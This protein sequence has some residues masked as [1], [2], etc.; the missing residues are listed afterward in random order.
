MQ[1]STTDAHDSLGPLSQP[2]PPPLPSPTSSLSSLSSLSRSPSPSPFDSASQQSASSSSRPSTGAYEAVG[3][4]PRRS[5]E[6]TSA[7]EQD[8]DDEAFDPIKAFD[9]SY[10][11]GSAG[12]E[13]W[14]AEMDAALFKGFA[15]IPNATSTVYKHEGR[16]VGRPALLA[17]F[18]RR[19][20]GEVRSAGQVS[21]R[22]R[23]IRA[24]VG[25]DERLLSLFHEE[26]TRDPAILRRDWDAYLGPDLYP[27]APKRKKPKKDKKPRRAPSHSSPPLSPRKKP[28][29]VVPLISPT[30]F[31]P[32]RSAFFPSPS[33][34]YNAAHPDPTPLSSF[35]SFPQPASQPC[36]PA[37]P[38]PVPLYNAPPA[39]GSSSFVGRD[40]QPLQPQHLEAF[41]SSALPFCGRRAVFLF[42]RL[43]ITAMLDCTNLV[44]LGDG[45]FKALLESVD[46][47]QDVEANERRVVR[48]ALEAVRRAFTAGAER[49]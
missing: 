21:R 6:G 10:V 37:P 39:Y 29:P 5:M 30:A 34:S 32:S 26:E 20:T 27:H 43:G 12:Y 36:Y 18:I 23:S 44:E 25:G 24:K 8:D 7:G 45:A 11:R 49:S 38:P 13:S 4:G 3:G 46:G 41:L 48:S 14:T 22:M 2:L 42:S 47:M 15:L 16:F 17:E 19:Q 28:R 9:M 31:F 33:M 35:S 1:G 40:G